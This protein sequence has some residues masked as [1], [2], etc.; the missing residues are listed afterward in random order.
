MKNKNG[1]SVYNFEIRFETI[2]IAEEK[3]I[4]VQV[5]IQ[6]IGNV[7]SI[8]FDSTKKGS[9]FTDFPNRWLL[10]S[11]FEVSVKQSLKCSTVSCFVLCHF[12]HCVVNSVKVLFL[13]KL[14]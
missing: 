11:L 13:C 2:F 10:N 5:K 7:K 8:V 6:Y 9:P 14:S 3:I 1:F 4:I 12:V